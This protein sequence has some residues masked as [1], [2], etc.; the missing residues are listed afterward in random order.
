MN[1]VTEL[2][3]T[4]TSKPNGENTHGQEGRS[5]PEE[6]TT[7]GTE[8]KNSAAGESGARRRNKKSLAASPIWRHH[9]SDGTGDLPSYRRIILYI[10]RETCLV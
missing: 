9:S 4:A 6:Q 2:H 1:S 5:G 8:V 10:P 7:K 3:N